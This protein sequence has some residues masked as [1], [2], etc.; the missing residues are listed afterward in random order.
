MQPHPTG[1][2]SLE[3]RHP[4]PH[5]AAAPP[6]A[7]RP[8]PPR[9]ITALRTVAP[10]AIGSRSPNRHGRV[11]PVGSGSAPTVRTAGSRRTRASSRASARSPS[12][13]A[14]RGVSSSSPSR[15]RIAPERSSA[16]SISLSSR[17]SRTA[18]SPRWR[19]SASSSTSSRVAPW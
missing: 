3:H 7:L 1:R 17:R 6:P 5:L 14:P 11:W 18:S 12:S 8:R 10:G 15:T 4:G 2:A 19:R 9:R 16:R 13:R